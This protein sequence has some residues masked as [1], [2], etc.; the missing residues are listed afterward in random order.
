VSIEFGLGKQPP[1]LHFSYEKFSSDSHDFTF[2]ETFLDATTV[3]VGN[4]LNAALLRE[5][6]GKCTA[7]D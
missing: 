3:L 1:Y 6:F 2:N 4:Y 7:A 5:I